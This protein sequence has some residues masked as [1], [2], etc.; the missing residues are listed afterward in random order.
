MKS[1]IHKSLEDIQSVISGL[2]GAVAGWPTPKGPTRIDVVRE[3]LVDVNL[4]VEYAPDLSPALAF[5]RATADY[6]RE[7]RK[8]EKVNRVGDLQ[9]FQ[10]TWV[11]NDGK[12]LTHTKQCIVFLNCING[13]LTGDNSSVVDDI[14]GRMDTENLYRNGQDITRIIQ[15]VCKGNAD[16]FEIVDG[17]GV[18]YFVPV[19]HVPLLLRLQ[20]FIE[21]CSGRLS[22]FPVPKDDAISKQSVTAA[23]NNG[24]TVLLDNL[25]V[26]AKAIEEAAIETEGRKTRKS[27]LESRIKEWEEAKF[28]IN[29][30]H[31]YLGGCRGRLSARAAEIGERFSTLLNNWE[32]E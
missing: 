14:K 5:S 8:V 30:Y 19:E 26:A 9:S 2:S 28:K 31:E 20:T 22:L 13:E 3:A 12:E 27:T 32:E 10:V 7:G 1:P 11:A 15:K 16:F 25:E 18:A 24:L 29:A 23:V 17:K 4:P 6:K 21:K